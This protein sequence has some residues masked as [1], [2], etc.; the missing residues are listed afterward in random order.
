[1]KISVVTAIYNREATIARAMES[2]Q[3]QTWKNKQQIII[4]GA[5]TDR[6]MEIVQNFTDEKSIVVSERDKGIYDA[7]NKG[8]ALATGD[9]VGLLHSDDFFANSSILAQIAGAFE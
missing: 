7:I 6:T 9:V 8:I 4:D 2:F 3:Q 1:M 5:S